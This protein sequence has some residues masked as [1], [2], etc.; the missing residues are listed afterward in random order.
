MS[1]RRTFVPRRSASRAEYK[2]MDSSPN[3]VIVNVHASDDLRSDVENFTSNTGTTGVNENFNADG[4]AI[5]LYQHPRMTGARENSRSFNLDGI[6]R[7]D[8]T[9]ATEDTAKQPYP[10]LEKA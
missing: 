5:N 6:S 3:H 4:D 1:A 10:S 8:M 9:P 2:A 7:P